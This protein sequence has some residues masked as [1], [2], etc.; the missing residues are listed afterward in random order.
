MEQAAEKEQAVKAGF[1]QAEVDAGE[2]V[3]PERY[4][5]LKPLGI[6]TFGTVL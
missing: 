4:Q 5:D 3:V 1:Y 6:G 2:W